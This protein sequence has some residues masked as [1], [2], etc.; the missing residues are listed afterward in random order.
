MASKAPARNSRRALGDISN[1]I[2]RGVYGKSQQVNRPVTRG[3]CAQLPAN[4]QACNVENNYKKKPVIADGAAVVPERKIINKPPQKEVVVV[5]PVIEIRLDAEEAD[6]EKPGT[7]E[8]SVKDVQNSTSVLS[9]SSKVACGL[10]D[11]TKKGQIVDID[12]GDVGNQLAAVEYVKDLYKFYKL[13]EKYEDDSGRITEVHHVF[14][15][16]PE[17]LYLA[18]QIIDRYLSAHL[19]QRKELQLLGISSLLI[20]SKYEE[21]WAPTVSD[22]VS[23]SERAYSKEHILGMEKSILAKLGWSLT[24]PTPYVFLVRFIKAAMADKEMENMAF[25]LTELGLM[26]YEMVKLCPSML[27]ASAVYAARCTLNKTPL[28]DETLNLHTGFCES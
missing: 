16:S 13:A 28:W 20:A 24:G 12:A 14:K 6:K 3:F 2:I 9:P 7:Q 17:T 22:L 15:L 25:F 8:S 19:V 26:Q 1:L 5:K 21:I 18:I 11:V 10:A 27:A 23:I 4:A